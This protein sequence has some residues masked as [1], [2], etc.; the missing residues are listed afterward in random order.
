L[1]DGANSK[2]TVISAGLVFTGGGINI[3]LDSVCNRVSSITEKTFKIYHTHTQTKA[4]RTLILC[5]WSCLLAMTSCDL[6]KNNGGETQPLLSDSE[7]TD[8][9]F[10]AHEGEIDSTEMIRLKMPSDLRGGVI[11][12][13]EITIGKKVKT[14]FGFGTNR[15]MVETRT[16]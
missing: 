8:S 5:A 1:I 4:N 10:E 16:D 12:R 9:I 15:V 3:A 6:E 7:K 14:G 2:T 11:F 13:G